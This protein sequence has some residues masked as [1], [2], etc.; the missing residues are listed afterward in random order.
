MAAHIRN[1]ILIAD[2]MVSNRIFLRNILKDDYELIEAANGEMAIQQVQRCRDQIA[3]VLLD[4]VMPGKDGIQTLCELRKMGCLDEF[5]VLVVT[6]DRNVKNEARILELG[7][8]DMIH[9]PYDPVVIKR[10]ISNFIELFSGRKKMENRADD[11]ARAVNMSSMGVISMLATVTEFRSLESG[12]HTLRIQSFTKILLGAV[13]ELCPQYALTRRDIDLIANAAILHDVGKVMIPD[14][15]L[16]KPGKL[17]TEEFEVMK[18]HAMAGG[19]IVKK[20]TGMLEDQF[21]RYAY[22]IC[23]YHHERWDGKGYPDGLKRDNIPL[24][25]QV[26]SICDVYDALTTPRVYKKAFSHERAVE[27]ILNGECGVFNPEMLMCFKHVL[28]QFKDCAREYADSELVP[29]AS[30]IHMPEPVPSAT[31]LHT[32]TEQMAIA[33]YYAICRMIDGIVLETDMS[34]GTYELVYDTSGSFEALR[35]GGNLNET[36]LE[37]LNTVVHP[38]DKAIATRHLLDFQRDFFESGVRRQAERYRVRSSPEEEYFWVEANHLRVYTKNPNDR[39]ALCVWKRSE[40][41]EECRRR[42]AQEEKVYRPQL[43]KLPWVT[44][45]CRQDRWMTIEEGMESL[46]SLLGYQLPEMDEICHGRLSELI[47]PEDQERVRSFLYK[48]REQR[49]CVAVEYRLRHKDGS[50]IWVT[51]RNKIVMEGDGREHV[52]RVL[53]DNTQTHE[54]LQET[55]L[56]LERQQLLL[57]NA[58]EIFFE[59]DMLRDELY[60]TDNFQDTFGYSIKGTQFSRQKEKH[61]RMVHKEDLPQ[62]ETLIDSVNSSTSVAEQEIRIMKADGRYLWCRVRLVSQQWENGKTVSVL[63]AI[64]N[65]NADKLMMQS[66]KDQTQKDA[67]TGLTNRAAA[68]AW[69]EKYLRKNDGDSQAA[70][71]VLDIDNFKRVNDTYGHAAGDSVLVACGETIRQQFRSQDIVARLGG[72][73][74][75]IFLRDVVDKQAAERCCQKLVE[76]FASD[77]STLVPDCQISCSVGIAMYPQDGKQFLQL[78]K[79]ADKALLYAKQNG[80]NQYAAF[81]DIEEGEVIYRST[82]TEIESN[83]ETQL[84]DQGLVAYTM[85]YLYRSGDPEKTISKVLGMVGR[86]I[87]VSRVYVFE[88][89]RDNKYCSNTFEWCNE[90]IPS[91]QAQQ[92]KLSYATTMKAWSTRF[93]ES[94]IYYCRDTATLPEEIRA[95]SETYGEKSFLHC[96]IRDNG[97]LSGFVGFSDCMVSRLWTQEQMMVLESF[98]ELLSLFLLK[99]RAGDDRDKWTENVLHILDHSHEWVYLIDPDTYQLKFVN[100]TLKKMIP[101]LELGQR[102]YEK[103][104]G[105]KS[106]CLNCPAQKIREGESG[107]VELMNDVLKKKVKIQGTKLF[108][109]D[110]DAALLTCGESGDDS[111]QKGGG[112]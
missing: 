79:N 112:S 7:A 55:R 40:S 50:T 49:S 45:R 111:E 48:A 54:E 97:E 15:I 37:L 66:L 71:L 46:A 22:N 107:A 38:D 58:S 109:G 86:E 75:L 16:H 4:L 14:N 82:R 5:P 72:D 96:A 3:A 67:L 105:R 13:A 77:V 11:L 89:S 43:K 91:V 34:T 18:S 31:I 53:L 95:L 12:Q 30:D 73:E 24:S 2:D 28:G 85:H 61:C 17:T 8:T 74:F 93:E 33:K 41:D 101:N 57:N 25:A 27:M 56:K 59:W 35:S 19:E 1:T 108:W 23:R 81:S 42:Q 90:G 62:L 94:D 100:S 92:Q 110:E 103:I 80:K 99:K 21:V 29:D 9:K 39:R 68:S 84:S 26:V 10:R 32:Q 6:A 87:N 102:C 60:I 36:L 52:Y 76:H 104:M 98:A 70:V 64:T 44:L 20:M 78:Q 63:G 65:I 88:N 83:R 47:V 106:P 51:D 69:I